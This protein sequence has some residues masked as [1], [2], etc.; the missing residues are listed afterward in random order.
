MLRRLLGEAVDLKTVTSERGRVKADASQLEQVLVNLSLN[1]RD[2]MVDGGTLTIETADVVIDEDMSRHDPNLPAGPYVMIAVTDT[3]IGM[4]N[5]TRRR[6]F[7]PFFSTKEQ[8]KGTGLGLAS[9]YGVVKQSGGHITVRSQLGRGTTFTMY[10]PPTFE[11][12][13]VEHADMLE[14]PARG[15]VETILLVEDEVALLDFARK[16]LEQHGYTVHAHSDPDAAIRFASSLTGPIDLIVSDVVLSGLTGPTMVARLR[17]LR[18]D[19][20]VVYVSGYTADAIVRQ[21]TPGSGVSFLPKPFSASE[22]ARQVRDA[23]DSVAQLKG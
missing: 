2:A 19:V 5:V 16:A 6:V 7:E 23:L 17:Q 9:V 18:A 8:G 22:L 15:G 14:T 13:E 10:F 4:D 11:S 20:P 21:I 1:A 3:G 12:P